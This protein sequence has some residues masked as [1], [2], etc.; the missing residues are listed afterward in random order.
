MIGQI[1]QK[2]QT[3]REIRTTDGNVAL[4]K[5][6][7]NF[8]YE[9]YIRER[10]PVSGYY[11]K[12]GIPVQP[13]KPLDFLVPTITYSDDPEHE[14]ALVSQLR[15]HINP[16]DKTVVVGAGSGTT[17]VIAAKQAG[18]DSSVVAFEGSDRSA[19]KARQ[20]VSLNEVQNRCEVRHSIVGPAIHLASSEEPSV[21]ADQV[22][23]DDL[24]NCDVLELDCEGA[25]K[26]I[27]E[28]LDITPR[29][30][31]VETHPHFDAETET[32]EAILD[33][34]GYRVV[35]RI[36][37]SSVPVLTAK[38]EPRVSGDLSH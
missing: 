29:V 36:D 38:Y 26:E 17:T 16:G 10:L 4:I 20:T 18:E 31:I 7:V 5:A 6:T 37:R 22:L 19:R 13:R 30:I 35:N 34:H 11:T 24:P 1:R 3:A 27:L 33:D 8:V 9:G 2:A 28:N 23:P 32:I 15:S 14:Y 25:E 21:Q 12:A